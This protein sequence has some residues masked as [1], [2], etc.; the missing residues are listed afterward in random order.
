MRLGTRGLTAAMGL[1]WGGV[2]L[3]VGVLNLLYPSYGVAFLE[4]T[5]SIYPGYHGP[6]GFVSVLVATLYGLV[7]GA[8]GGF[9]LAWLYNAFA[10]LERKASAPSV[11]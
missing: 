6:A 2:I 5:A 4:W 11:D 8:I 10:G 7:D 1:L 9:V 3:L